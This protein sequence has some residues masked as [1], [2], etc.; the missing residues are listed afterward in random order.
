MRMLENKPGTLIPTVPEAGLVIHV[1]GLVR[2][3]VPL[4]ALSVHPT[5]YSVYLSQQDF[6]FAVSE[7]GNPKVINR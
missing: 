2:I 4:A 7:R 3:N 6:C 1:K 5:L